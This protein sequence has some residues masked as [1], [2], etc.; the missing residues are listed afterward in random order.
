[1][2]WKETCAMELK[3]EMI[4][5]WLKKEHNITDLSTGYGVSRKTIYKWIERFKL[6]GFVGLEE[7]SREPLHHPNAIP[8]EI[9]EM[10]LDLKRQKMKWGPRKILA[11]LKNDQP[12]IPWP[13]DSTGNNLLKK[14][15]LVFPRKRRLRTPPYT[16]PF[17]GCDQPNDVWSADYKGQFKMGNARRCYPL[18]ISDN[19]SR[20]LLGCWGLTRS[21]YEQTKPYFEWAFIHYGLPNAIRTDN[22]QPFAS[23]GIG[24]LSKL[25]VWFIKLGIRPERID[26]GCPEQNG[27]HERMHRTL[28]EATARP[29]KANLGE[30]QT[31][32]DAFLEEYN[33]ERPH[34]ALGQRPP[35]SI[36][37]TSPRIY[38]VKMRKVEYDS[39]V[40]VRF[41]TN[42]GCIKWQGD[43]IF[44]GEPLSGEYVSLKQVADHR[45]EIRFSFYL[46]GH[47]DE[48]KKKV[49]R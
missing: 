49:I 16:T 38:P 25:G 40:T 39:D 41:V 14:H 29:P 10:I 23:R 42:R 26:L 11:K 18:T 1:M 28:K 12:D 5:D 6:D 7:L 31:A 36:H 46:L 35:A 20:Y 4:N 45:W 47:L 24:G 43:L 48:T 19:Y 34:E 44:L 2:P 33:E 15:G 21:T 9:A 32:F 13:S 37:Q 22:G 17:L 8:I 27:R 30:Q 3:R